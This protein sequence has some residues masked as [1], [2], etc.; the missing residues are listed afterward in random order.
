MQ[1]NA[2]H[3]AHKHT[4]QK[5]LQNEGTTEA[6]RPSSSITAITITAITITTIT[7]TIT[8]TIIIT[9]SKPGAVIHL[10]ALYGTRVPPALGIHFE[11]LRHQDTT[12]SHTA[13]TRNVTSQL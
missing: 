1:Y 7:I 6:A 5:G 12:S 13:R 4:S 8:I 10:R 11:T 9:F 3:R 2:P